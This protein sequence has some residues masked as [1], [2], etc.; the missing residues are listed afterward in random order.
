[1]KKL[2]RDATEDENLEPGTR[3][4]PTRRASHMMKQTIDLLVATYP[5]LHCA[6]V[7]IE[8]GT[9]RLNYAANIERPDAI[10]LFKALAHR[11]QK[12]TQ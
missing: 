7:V 5:G 12:E 10:A 1:M 6:V 8:P 11:L 2:A 3:S 4:D 9:D